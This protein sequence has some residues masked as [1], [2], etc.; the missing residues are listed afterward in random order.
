ME[1]GERFLNQ[2][3]AIDSESELESWALR[4]SM[5][6]GGQITGGGGGGRSRSGTTDTASGPGEW[7]QN[8]EPVPPLPTRTDN[9]VE[10]LRPPMPERPR[11]PCE[12]SIGWDFCSHYVY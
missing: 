1:A 11:V 2:V 4:E 9:E 3:L 12:P 5:R 6:A 7:G 10:T 8:A